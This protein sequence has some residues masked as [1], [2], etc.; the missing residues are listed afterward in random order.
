MKFLIFSLL[1]ALTGQAIAQMPIVG[2]WYNAYSKNSQEFYSPESLTR[3]NSDG[4]VTWEILFPG[5]TQ[6]QVVVFKGHLTNDSIQ[7]TSIVSK[8][9]CDINFAVDAYPRKYFIKGDLLN[10]EHSASYVRASQ[11]QLQK[12]LD[13]T[14]GCN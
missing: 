1:M 7:L 4:T 3:I 13:I 12:F 10:I 5:S 2:V 8:T 14:E 11:E 9:N 6:K